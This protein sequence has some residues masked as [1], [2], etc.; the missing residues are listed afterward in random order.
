MEKDGRLTPMF[1]YGSRRA[2]WKDVADADLE[3]LTDQLG[4]AA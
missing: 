1:K 4:K 3:R 2:Q